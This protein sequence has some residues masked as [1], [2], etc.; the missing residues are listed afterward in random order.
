VAEGPRLEVVRDLEP[1]STALA[2]SS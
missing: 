1:D 2:A